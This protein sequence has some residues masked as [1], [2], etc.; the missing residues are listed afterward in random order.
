MKRRITI[1]CFSLIL[2]LL[3]SACVRSGSA[4]PAA[5]TEAS[6]AVEDGSV[7]PL[8]P[9]DERVE[10]N[11]LEPYK[12]DAGEKE[13]V[14]LLLAGKRASIFR[15]S[16]DNMLSGVSMWYEEYRNGELV[17]SGPHQDFS[18][19]DYDREGLLAVVCDMDSEGQM[20]IQSGSRRGSASFYLES[21]VNLEESDMG[22]YTSSEL[23]K[24]AELSPGLEIPLYII[25]GGNNEN[26]AHLWHPEYYVDNPEK[27]ADLDYAYVFKCCFYIQ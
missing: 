4:A 7:E 15:F 17:S 16:V 25:A 3:L 10:T 14:D 23:Y 19:V 1:L 20:S 24:K 6:G 12:W 27:L 26:D 5:S 9:E 11:I 21:K 13:L 18:L 8:E 2:L 22:W